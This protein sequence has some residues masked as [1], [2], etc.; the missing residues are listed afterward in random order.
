MESLTTRRVR[1]RRRCSRW[2]CLGQV[3]NH[4]RE[5]RPVSIMT[6]F[7]HCLRSGVNAILLTGT[8]VGA[9]GHGELR[10]EPVDQP[11]HPPE[12]NE[13]FKDP[14]LL[15]YHARLWAG[16]PSAVSV[17]I[18][19]TLNLDRKNA[20]NSINYSVVTG[21]TTTVE[22]GENS[23]AGRVGFTTG[24]FTMLAGNRINI[25]AVGMRV[26]ED[27]WGF[28]AGPWYYGIDV[29]ANVSAFQGRIGVVQ[30]GHGDAAAVFGIGIGL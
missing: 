17:E 15:F 4:V 24:T 21:P 8:I 7:L 28:E 27:R 1:C 29:T 19:V 12:T 6:M 14:G 16:R 18:G 9:D 30:S 23:L 25:S 3:N 13:W 2:R 20:L 22:I 5:K 10:Q 11:V 26:W